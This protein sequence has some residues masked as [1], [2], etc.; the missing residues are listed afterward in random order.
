[1]ISIAPLIFPILGHAVHLRFPV[2]DLDDSP[3]YVT[4]PETLAVNS[5]EVSLHI[6]EACDLGLVAKFN[7]SF[8]GNRQYV[9]V[10]YF[11]FDPKP[12]R[13]VSTVCVNKQPIGS[14]E[15]FVSPRI[16]I[17][18]FP[19]QTIEM[20]QFMNYGWAHKFPSI[21]C[22]GCN[23]SLNVLSFKK[24]VKGE[25]VCAGRREQNN[26]FYNISTMNGDIAELFPFRL[27]VENQSLEA[28]TVSTQR[29]PAYDDTL[30]PI[31]EPVHVCFYSSPMAGNGQHLGTAEFLLS[32]NDTSALVFFILFCG[33]LFPI[34]CITS[35]AL[36]CYRLRRHRQFIRSV[37]HR[38]QTFQLEREMLLH[39]PFQQVLPQ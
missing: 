17:D 19:K 14:L 4:I 20:R 16:S 9:P 7:G 38:I 15:Y 24:V 22:E 26:V 29:F 36:H 39:Q 12:P 33:V 28:W 31:K 34:V 37:K 30:M 32:D 8:P 18:T 23:Q 35:T 6:D 11:V 13:D 5:T 2:E 3:V 27:N 25:Q 21:P 10:S 1:M